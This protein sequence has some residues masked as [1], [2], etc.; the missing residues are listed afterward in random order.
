MAKIR[1]QHT[2]SLTEEEEQ[3]LQE[4]IKQEWSVINI[5]RVGI[6]QI[7]VMKDKAKGLIK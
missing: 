2:F 1:I 5:I 4:L 7:E 6:E 3:R